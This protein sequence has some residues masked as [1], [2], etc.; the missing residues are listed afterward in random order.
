MIFLILLL[1]LMPLTAGAQYR[2]GPVRLDDRAD[3]LFFYPLMRGNAADL[4]CVWASATDA[5][6]AAIGQRMS[7]GGDAIGGRITY[8]DLPVG[9]ATCPASVQFVMLPT[10][11]E[12]RLLHH[13]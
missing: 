11:E 6:L 13:S 1:A 2:F 5:H 3:T 12:I 4:L 8:E 10:G 9:Q 7:L